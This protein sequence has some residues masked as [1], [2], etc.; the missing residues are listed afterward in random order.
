MSLNRI[1]LNFGNDLYQ[2]LTVKN[3]KKDMQS[4]QRVLR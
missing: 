3:L 1:F 2:K 4:L